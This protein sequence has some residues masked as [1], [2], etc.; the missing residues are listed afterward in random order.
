VSDIALVTGGAGLIGSHIA[1]ELQAL[2]WTVRVLDSLDPETHAGGSKPDWVNDDIDFIHGDV[3][4]PEAVQKA[5]KDAR[6]IFH[7]AA[8]GGFTSEISRYFEVNVVGTANI[9]SAIRQTGQHPEKIVVASSQALYGEGTYLN[10]ETASQVHPEGRTLRQ[11]NAGQWD[12]LTGSGLR[13]MPLLTS[14]DE[15]ASGFTPY[16]LSKAAQEKT[17]LGLGRLLSI[18]VVALRYAVTFGPRQSLHNPYTGVVSIFSNLSRA[19][20]SPIVYEDGLQTRDFITARDQAR[21]NVFVALNT[22]INNAALNSGRGEAVA[23]QD[24]ATY[25][26]NKLDSP[27]P[28]IPGEFRLGDVR[29]IVH[30]SSR[31]YSYG[32]RPSD[33]WQQGID[34]YMSWFL[35]QPPAEDRFP[36]SQKNLRQAGVLH[37]VNK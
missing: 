29:H 22:G 24:F 6:L 10:P 15:A 12:H 25:I 11:L 9:F 23:M 31:L 30:D 35:K 26:A 17:A 33:S 18:P 20:R 16:A 8:F 19:G 36:D 7:Q 32:F 28:V 3:R 14:E 13:L 5:V 1:D 21:A 4:D 34:D 2:G 37:Q 27:A